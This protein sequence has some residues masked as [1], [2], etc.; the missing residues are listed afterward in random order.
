M[1]LADN[2]TFNLNLIEDRPVIGYLFDELSIL[3]NRTKAFVFRYDE[4]G[5]IKIYKIIV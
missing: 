5:I 4:N 3:K 1:D 2:S